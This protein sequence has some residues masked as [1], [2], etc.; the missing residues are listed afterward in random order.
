MQVMQTYGKLVIDLD[1]SLVRPMNFKARIKAYD[2]SLNDDQRAEIQ[3]VLD[4]A[5]AAAEAMQAKMDAVEESGNEEEAIDLN[6]GVQEVYLQFQDAF[7]GLDFINVD[8]IIRHDMYEDNVDNL[9]AAI[10]ALEDGDVQ[11]AVDDYLS[12]VDW[13]WYDMNFDEETCDYMKNQLFEKRDDTWGAGL[14]E[15]K[16][17]DTGDVTRSLCAKYDEENPDVT[18][19]IEQLKALKATQ[20]DYLK[21]VYASE[22]EGLQKATSLMIKYAK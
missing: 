4:E 15:F 19:E 16:H 12:A 22:L 17:A 1:G 7:L 11:T 6:K 3:P 2:K 20:E 10:K 5:Y 21:Q 9:D 18:A 8:A 13:S 14:I